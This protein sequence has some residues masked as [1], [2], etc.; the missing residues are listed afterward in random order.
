MVSLADMLQGF[1]VAAASV[2]FGAWMGSWTAGLTAFFV[3][4]LLALIR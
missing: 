2:S 4:L 1:L 3:L